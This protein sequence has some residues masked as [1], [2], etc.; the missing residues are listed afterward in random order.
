METL[1]IQYIGKKALCHDSVAGTGLTWRPGE[2]HPVP[3]AQA[4][5]LLRHTDV[6]ATEDGEQVA[7]APALTPVNRPEPQVE[8]PLMPPVQNLAKPQLIELARTQ[9]GEMLDPAMKVGDMRKRIV[10]LQNSGRQRAA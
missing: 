4:L 9:F 10:S 5:M 8:P 7:A 1:N 3:I 2:V 6:W